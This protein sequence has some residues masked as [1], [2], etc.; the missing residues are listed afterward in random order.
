MTH[1][2][3]V[4]FPP[5]LRDL[6]SIL[7]FIL[8]P[9]TLSPFFKLSFFPKHPT[10]QNVTKKKENNIE[11]RRRDCLAK[12]NIEIGKKGKPK[13]KYCIQAYLYSFCNMVT[14]L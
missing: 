5:S 14:T 8:K 2:S 7:F 9:F 6:Y 12:K 13:I 11:S 10:I 3:F 4:I 1:I